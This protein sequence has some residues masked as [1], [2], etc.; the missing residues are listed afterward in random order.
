M[1]FPFFFVVSIRMRF[2]YF[3]SAWAFS[4]ER[5][6]Y[7]FPE[8]LLRPERKEAPILPKR[9]VGHWVTGHRRKHL[10]P[11]MTIL[12]LNKKWLFWNWNEFLILFWF[13]QAGRFNYVQKKKFASSQMLIMLNWWLNK[14]PVNSSIWKI[15][16]K[17]FAQKTQM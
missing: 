2:P 8:F 5:Q 16:H 11:K 10:D 7:F 12:K 6:Q 9:N 13:K 15:A 17:A 14:K 1:S 3:E 4:V